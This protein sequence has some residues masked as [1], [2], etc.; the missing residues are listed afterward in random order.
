MLSRIFK[1]T[2]RSVAMILKPMRLQPF[3]STTAAPANQAASTSSSNTVSKFEVEACKRDLDQS[4]WKMRFLVYLIRDAWVPDAMAQLKFNPK[5][6]CMDVAKLLNRAC[7]LARVSHDA[8]PEEMYVKQVWVTKGKSQ[9]RIRIMGR[10]R[11][12]IGYKRWSHVFVKL[13]LVDFEDLIK[14]G[15]PSER[16]LWARRME[17][18][19]EARLKRQLGQGEATS[20][21]TSQDKQ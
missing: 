20:I 21:M 14:N 17:V 5:P 18:A 11:T 6:K 4:P 13:S 7:A 19:K 10:G 3:S 12:G 16:K 1:P 9:K 8:L 15:K 2:V